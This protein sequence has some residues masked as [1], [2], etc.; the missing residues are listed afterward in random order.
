VIKI[1][2]IATK[3]SLSKESIKKVKRPFQGVEIAVDIEK[4]SDSR[5]SKIKGKNIIFP[6]E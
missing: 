3:I 4:T 6:S 5:R 2:N 1:P